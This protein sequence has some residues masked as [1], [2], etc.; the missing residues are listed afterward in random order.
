MGRDSLILSGFIYIITH[1]DYPFSC[2]IG[3][4]KEPRQ[5]VS[6]ANIWCPLA[7]Y[8]LEEMVYFDDVKLAEYTLHKL[9]DDRRHEH[10]EWFNLSPE[11]A[12][13]EILK[14]RDKEIQNAD[15]AD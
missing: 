7:G 15:S 5:R 8:N 9:L 13:Q 3:F 2:K 10:G 14:L 11:E 1:P 4:S 6:Q 12:L